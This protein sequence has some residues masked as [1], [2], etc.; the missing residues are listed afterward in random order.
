MTL[1]MTRAG[2]EPKIADDA[3]WPGLPVELDAI[4]R[5]RPVSAP[6]D[7]WLTLRLCRYRRRETVPAPIW[8]A[9][10]AMAARADALVSVQTLI[11]LTRVAVARPDSV[12]LAAGAVFSGRAI[13]AL[14]GGCPLAVAFVLT[15]GP[16]L[17][18]EATAL[19]ER[20]DLLEAF[21]LETA[22]WAALETAVRALRLDLVARARSR[23]WRVTHRLAPGYLDWPIEEQR[24]LMGLFGDAD[25][26]VRL[27]E[28]GVLVPMKSVTG[29]FGL[30]PAR[31]G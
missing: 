11:R 24:A 4:E 22:G 1:A 10:R 17:E 19:A 27:S 26:L 25:G 20:R 18:A 2:T 13:G 30:A 31:S 28:H 14:L 7:P 29:V 15:L 16:R 12:R 21:L 6:I 8:E 23:H 5:W 3:A 9:A